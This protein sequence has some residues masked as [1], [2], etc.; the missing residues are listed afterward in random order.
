[1]KSIK[2]DR[3]CEPTITYPCLMTGERY[4]GVLLIT[5]VEGQQA[6]GTL[7]VKGSDNNPYPIG[8]YEERWDISYLKPYNG[9]VCLEN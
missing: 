6:T 7:L 9:S 3:S 2:S 1:M 5:K 4:G 8:A